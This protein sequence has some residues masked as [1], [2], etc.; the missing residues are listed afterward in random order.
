M[1][2]GRMERV[3]AA[4][5][6]WAQVARCLAAGPLL[7]A[8]RLSDQQAVIDADVRRWVDVLQMSDERRALNRL[9]YAFPE[10]RA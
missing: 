8:Y 9:L 5:L 7:W 6:R 2:S 4:A 10:F 3:A 1:P